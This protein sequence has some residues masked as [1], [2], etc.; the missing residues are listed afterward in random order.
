MVSDVALKKII[1]QRLPHKI[2]QQ[3]HTLDLTGKSYQEI[4]TIITN[5]DRTAESWA[6]PGKNFELEATRN[7]SIINI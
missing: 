6:A 1:V 3:M 7:R 5:A 4:I 2:I